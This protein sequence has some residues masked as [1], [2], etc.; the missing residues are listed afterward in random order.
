MSDTVIKNNQEQAVAAWINYLNQLRINELQEKLSLIADELKKGLITQDQYFNNALSELDK[1]LNLI[2]S[3]IRRGAETGAH[4]FISEKAQ[5]A[6]GNAR[7][8]IEGLK[9]EYELIDNNGQWDIKKNGIPIQM[10]FYASQDHMSLEACLRHLK[11]Y[12]DSFKQ[13]GMYMI[14]KDHYEKMKY[15]LS[16]SENQA[17]KMGTQTG[18]FS[19]SEWKYV[20]KFVEENKI[21]Q[22]KIIPSDL[23]YEEVQ[24]GTYEKTFS[25][26]K[27]SL[28]DK[29]EAAKKKLENQAD[30]KAHIAQKEAMPT[31]EEAAKATVVSALIE[32][33]TAFCIDIVKMH[34]ER[35]SFHAFSD[36]DWETIAKET[37]NSTMKGA[38]RGASIYV[39][40]N[41]TATPAAVASS[42]VT[43][44]FGVIEQANKYKNGE[45]SEVELIHNSEI[46]CLDASISAA[47][48]LIG[49]A[50]IPIPV[51]GAVIG[52]TVGTMV[53]QIIKENYGEDK[54]MLS[55]IKNY[56]IEMD[57]QLADLESQYKNFIINLNR[58]MEMY[59]NI[60]PIAFS[61]NVEEAFKGSVVL[62]NWAGVPTEEIL[63]TKEKIDSFFID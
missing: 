49:Q 20:K 36:E 39:L 12:P 24:K 9:K 31:F 59:I 45:L 15:L 42:V 57:N 63:D 35:E 29:N 14:P 56:S 1:Y 22:D 46:L 38:V 32:G 3:S 6:I 51:V 11:M 28:F 7:K 10:K 40:T 17:N 44:A 43:A 54:Q 8:L 26:E 47:S 60:L 48:S 21:P 61:V 33:G 41:Y 23:T 50:V 4:G 37:A 27:V 55:L 13:G 18:D 2:R 58:N 53:Y 16:I 19:L 34:K 25:K 52:N 62:A 30:E 5:V